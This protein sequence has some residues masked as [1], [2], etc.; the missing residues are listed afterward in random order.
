MMLVGLVGLA[1]AF[2]F[3]AAG[4]LAGRRREHRTKGESVRAIESHRSYVEGPEDARLVMLQ[5]RD[6]EGESHRFA[7]HP[8]RA[9]LLSDDLII[10]AATALRPP[11]ERE[12]AEAAAS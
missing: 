1:V 9:Y 3:G 12:R 6:F 2:G 11:E 4:Y 5:I 10:K 8:K 7:I